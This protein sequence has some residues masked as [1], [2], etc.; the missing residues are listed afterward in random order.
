MAKYTNSSIS[1]SRVLNHESLF[2]SRGREGEEIDNR[3]KEILLNK[4]SSVINIFSTG[5]KIYEQS[6]EPI[7]RLIEDFEN[8]SRIRGEQLRKYL[9][10][11][12]K[13]E[14][15][16]DYAWDVWQ[17]VK[18]IFDDAGLCLEVPDASLGEAETLM[19]TWSKGEHYLECEIFSDKQIEFFYRNRDSGEL[20]GEDTTLEH[21]ISPEAVERLSLFAW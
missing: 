10:A 1:K 2:L 3:L 16:A 15:I 4:K 13:S 5:E 17:W 21:H 12:G 8:N 19:Y 14:N 18:C 7:Y 20:W 9:D 6:I 11:V